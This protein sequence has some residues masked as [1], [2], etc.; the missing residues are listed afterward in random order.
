[1]PTARGSTAFQTDF[2]FVEKKAVVKKRTFITGAFL[3]FGAFVAVQILLAQDAKDEPSQRPGRLR[4][5]TRREGDLRI[6]DKLKVGDAA[7]DF[8]LKSLDGKLTFKLSEFRNK[9]P[10]VLIFGSYT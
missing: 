1:M 3:L 6:P 8:E 7:P 10:V 5:Q 2:E 9:Q 4:P